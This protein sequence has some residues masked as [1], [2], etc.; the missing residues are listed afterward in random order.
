M[1]GGQRAEVRQSLPLDA[2]ERGWFSALPL[3]PARAW[4]RPHPER[5]E[6]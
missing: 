5:A 1:A 3:L 2:V 4:W 6:P